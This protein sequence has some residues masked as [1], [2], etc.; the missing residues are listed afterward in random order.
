MILTY[1]KF[2]AILKICTSHLPPNLP[3]AAIS[4]YITDSI[5]LT[6]LSRTITTVHSLWKWTELTSIST[7][8]HQTINQDMLLHPTTIVG[9]QWLWFYHSILCSTG[10]TINICI[11]HDYSQI[12]FTHR[13][14]KHKTW[15]VNSCKKNIL[16]KKLEHYLLRTYSTN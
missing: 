6:T 2:L 3:N 10:P 8:T 1:P 4:M 7:P 15:N 16:T 5:T 11:A 13:N 12:L 9:L 14:T